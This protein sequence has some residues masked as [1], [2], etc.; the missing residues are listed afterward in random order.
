VEASFSWWPSVALAR[1]DSSQVV[2]PLGHV[3]TLEGDVLGN[4]K[5]LSELDPG[6]APNPKSCLLPETRPRR[7][8]ARAKASPMLV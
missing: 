8:A 5:S 7:F 2:A 6:S 1:R 3:A 4:R